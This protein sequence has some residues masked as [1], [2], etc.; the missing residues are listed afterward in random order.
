[1]NIKLLVILLRVFDLL[2]WHRHVCSASFQAYASMLYLRKFKNFKIFLRG[3]PVEQFN[4]AD[5]LQYREV[6][7]YRPQVSSMKEVRLLYMMWLVYQ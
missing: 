5:E 1:M 4:I 2:I 7:T 3:K 6:V